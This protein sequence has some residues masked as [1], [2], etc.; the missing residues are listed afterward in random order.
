MEW[1]SCCVS[2]VS[3]DQDE[4]AQ[5]EIMH[6]HSLLIPTLWNHNWN[7]N[8]QSYCA[9]AFYEIRKNLTIHGQVLSWCFLTDH[10]CLSKRETSVQTYSQV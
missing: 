5:N 1:R 2:A 8:Q 7:H 4:C 10:L 6:G 3:I 9:I